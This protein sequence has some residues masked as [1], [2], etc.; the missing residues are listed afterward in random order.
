MEIKAYLC[1]QCGSSL[2]VEKDATFAVCPHCGCKLHISYG[3]NEKPKDPGK[4][5]FI[6]P[7]GINVGSAMV[8]DKYIT[9]ASITQR[10]Q[11]DHVPMIIGTSAVS[12][13]GQVIIL[14]SSKEMYE[15]YQ[16]AMV[17]NTLKSLP[18]TIQSG[19]R[20]F[21]EPHIYLYQYASAVAGC[22]LTPVAN[23]TLPSEYGRNPQGA[24][25]RHIAF[26]R[27]HTV[28]INV[29]IEIANAACKGI[30]VRYRG[31]KNGKDI[32]V[33]GGVDF[34]GIEYYDANNGLAQINSMMN[35]FAAF[36]GLFGS[37]ANAPQQ[38]RMQP[39][40]GEI[41]FGHAK[42][43]GK[44]VD[45]IQWGAARFYAAV[46]PAEKE[47]EGMN[48]FLSFVTTFGYDNNLKTE[49]NRLVDEM[50]R[51]RVLEAQGYAAQAQQARINLMQS[52]QNLQRTLA[53]NSQQISAGIMDSWDKKMASDSRISANYSEAVRGV[54]TY[55]GLDGRPVEV[56]VAADHVYQNQYGDTFGVSGN[57]IDPELANKINWTEIGQ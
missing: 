3:Q 9:S 1:P 39:P 38:N 47:A 27:S 6:S 29:R 30:M 45:C 36:G 2:N 4:T 33:L 20:D 16:N 41:P 40:N 37:S 52:Q 5:A 34:E 21:I 55:T 57:A 49:Y 28:N 54:N 18:S 13:D 7:E 42:E 50:Y 43:Y 19:L 31:N 10:W 48:A 26:F 12:P 25:G 14:S 22:R 17:R 56:S 23:A 46:F 11:S 53:Q 51:N 32:T 44:Q 15:D 8:P 35:P 24:V